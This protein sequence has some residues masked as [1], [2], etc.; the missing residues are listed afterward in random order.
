MTTYTSATLAAAIMGDEAVDTNKKAATRIIR[1]FLRDELGGGKAVVGKGSRYA[2]DYNKREITAMAKRF[3]AWEVAQDEAK[4]LRKEALEA[5]KAP[6]KP[7]IAELVKPTGVD[8][9]TLSDD[10]YDDEEIDEDDDK[11]A[12]GPTDEE[13]AAMLEDDDEDIEEL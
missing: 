8:P 3:K 1:K 10:E 4:A 6:A 5:A 12:T 7:S 2:L 13:I 9:L 11:P